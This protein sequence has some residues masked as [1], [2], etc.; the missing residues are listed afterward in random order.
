MKDRY[1][2]LVVGAGP[3][4]S[5]AA[6]AAADAG[7]SVL[8]TEKR[9]A[10]GSP[11]RC[12]EGI[13]KSDLEEFMEPDPKW[14]SRTITGGSFISADRSRF[15]VSGRCGEVLG[16][17]L[18]RKMFDRDLAMKA[19]NAGAEIAVHTRAIPLTGNGKLQG[20][21][22]H[23]HGNTYEVRA[24]VVI[25]ADGIES[26]F[27]RCAGISTTVPFTELASSVQY[28]AADIDINSEEL[29]F[30]VSQSECPDGY[31][32]VFPKGERCA[33]IGL[34]TGGLRTA[35]V[36]AKVLLDRFM[37]REFPDAKVLERIAGGYSSC[38][39][40]S[41]TVSDNLI[42]AGDA[43]RLCDPV[44]GGGI[45]QALSTGNLAGRTA[46]DAVRN[47]DTSEK[48]L[49]VY[50]E[51]WR[52]GP[53]GR[54]LQRSYA[55]KVLLSGADDISLNRLFHSMPDLQLPRVTVSATLRAI[56]RHCPGLL[57]ATLLNRFIPR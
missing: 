36:P 27:A 14:I 5:L 34:G 53:L 33:N 8:L 54:N 52:R 2:V 20:A 30:Y 46:A 17:I 6:K 57:A 47:G 51:T 10:I 37:E 55:V 44:T 26:V 40:L 56:L 50:D 24:G 31:I 18:E 19:E 21:V 7:C 12:A 48:A 49:M 13:F 29:L 43:A 4:G 9:P 38:K 11:V 1:D 32:W 28:L 3:A 22:L 39:P 16:Y 45:Y 25:A 15:R 23:Q 35:K 41:C 42:I